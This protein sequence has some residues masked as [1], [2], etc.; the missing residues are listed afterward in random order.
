MIDPTTFEDVLYEKRGRAAWI[1]I[2][3]AKL[4]NAFRAQTI[5]ELISACSP[6]ASM[7]QI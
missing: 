1:I 2:N 7:R 6:S 3:R 5:Q 4:Y